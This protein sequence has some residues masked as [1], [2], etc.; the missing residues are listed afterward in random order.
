M[1]GIPGAGVRM[2]ATISPCGK[3]RYWLSREG[4][5]SMRRVAFVMLNPSTADADIDDATIRRCRTFARGAG[6]V[7]VN[8]FA[9][10]ATK[11]ADMFAVGLGVAQGRDNYNYLLHVAQGD[12]KIIVAWGAQHK[13]IE[14]YVFD[15]VQILR[16]TSDDLT[17]NCLYCLGT[18]KDGHPRHPLYV[19]SD[20]PID[21]WVMP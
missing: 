6:F 5:A 7:V 18:T 11:P 21:P 12:Y 4:D 15:A 14:P 20:Q 16:W 9:Y 10:R 3:Y 19:K 13:V 8:L 17:P 1:G 2:S